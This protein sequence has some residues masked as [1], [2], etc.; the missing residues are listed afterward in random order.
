MIVLFFQPAAASST[1][2]TTDADSTISVRGSPVSVVASTSENV[3]DAEATASQGLATV[4]PPV[5]KF[6]C[7]FARVETHRDPAATA[8]EL[9]YDEKV[10][11]LNKKLLAQ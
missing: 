2:S 9:D 8:E 4:E 1:L 7:L 6:K 11:K 3:S 5:K 10:F